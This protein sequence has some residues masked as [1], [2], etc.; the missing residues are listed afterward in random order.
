M[1]EKV[2]QKANEKANESPLRI[3]NISGFYGD[4][5]SA[6]KEMVFPAHPDARPVDVLT[7]DYLAE[8]TM[9]ILLKDRTRDAN[10]GYARTFLRQLQDV[11]RACAQQGIK[12]VSNAGGLNPRGCAEACRRVLA[13]LELSPDELSNLR[14]A[15]LEGDDLLERLGELQRAGQELRHLDRDVPLR[16]L[17]H[18]VLSA[19]VYLGAW[20]IVEALERGAGLVVCPRVTDA[21]VVVGPAAWRFGWSRDDWD[22]LAGAVLAGHIIECSTQA[23]GGNYTFFDEIEDMLRPGF[24]IAEVS[25]DGSFVVTKHPGTGGAVTVG[26]VTAQLLYE[27]QSERYLNPDVVVRLDTVRIEQEGEDRVRVWGVRG[28]PAPEQL[29]VCMNYLGGYKNSVTLQLSGARQEEKAALAEE[30]FWGF[31]AGPEVWRSIEAGDVPDERPADLAR[32]QFAETA[33]HLK[34]G[35]EFSLLTLA[36]RDL[37][38]KKLSRGFWNA[39]VEMALAS[40]PGFHFVSSSRA[41]SEVTVY[42]PALIDRR[43]V[44]AKVVWIDA[45][46]AE[47]ERSV[48]DSVEGAAPAEPAPPIEPVPVCDDFYREQARGEDAALVAALAQDG[49]VRLGEFLGGRS[50]DKGGNCNVGIWARSVDGYRWILDHL[51]ADWLRSVYPEAQDLVVDRYELPGLLAVNFVVRGLLGE[52]VSASLRPDPQAKMVAEELLGT[53]LPS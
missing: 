27:I 4:R 51:D 7:G 52:G 32:A 37:D 29:K 21:S 23:T 19:N 2:I 10:G 46:G 14:V 31:L 22:Q 30:Q 33:A 44:D 16:E 53:G 48:S 13:G 43:F 28:E 47:Q 1:E 20:G 15:H 50:G 17:E 8:L 35:G 3:A 38:E 49:P 41:A 12:I 5:L 6:A 40:Y 34:R 42:W 45:E 18:E 39:A 36:A 9:M 26:T 25:A 11:G 24:P